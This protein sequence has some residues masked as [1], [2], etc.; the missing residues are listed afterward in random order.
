VVHCK[1][2]RDPPSN[3]KN[4]LSFGA[5][6]YR[7][8]RS[9]KWHEQRQLLR[10]DIDIS[11]LHECNIKKTNRYGESNSANVSKSAHNNF[12]NK[13]KM[14]PDLNIS[15]HTNVNENSL[16][17]SKANGGFRFQYHVQSKEYT[18]MEESDSSLSPSFSRSDRSIAAISLCSSTSERSIEIASSYSFSDEAEETKLVEKD[19]LHSLP[20]DSAALEDASSY[21]SKSGASSKGSRKRHSECISKNPTSDPFFDVQVTSSAKIREHPQSEFADIQV[22][23]QA[24]PATLDFS[25]LPPL[26]DLNGK[27]EKIPLKLNSMSFPSQTIPRMFCSSDLSSVIGEDIDMANDVNSTIV[28]PQKDRDGGSLFSTSPKSFLMGA[29]KKQRTIE[30]TEMESILTGLKDDAI[31]IANSGLKWCYRWF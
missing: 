31:G 23:L 5:A 15:V 28:Q 22:P 13:C 20:E 3:S 19:K 27:E 14:S 16:R 8:D 10:D 21:S 7:G 9:E 29:K 11:Q 12:F 6:Q 24:K 2:D 4:S 17:A 30:A 26:D 1:E 25:I 18:Q